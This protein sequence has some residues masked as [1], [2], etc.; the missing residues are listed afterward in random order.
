M[1][2]FAAATMKSSS[3]GDIS[4]DA[5]TLLCVPVGLTSVLLDELCSV[6]VAAE[7][8]SYRAAI[9]LVRVRTEL[10]AALERLASHEIP[11][12]S[13]AVGQNGSLDPVIQ[14]A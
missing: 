4:V 8:Q 12:A 11:A 14:Y 9:G 1:G 10:D 5:T 6:D 13:G 2:I 3:Q 7:H